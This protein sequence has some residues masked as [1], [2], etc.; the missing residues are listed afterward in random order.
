MGVTQIARRGVSII[1]Q[2]ILEHIHDK[3]T[4]VSVTI[5]IYWPS[6]NW[7]NENRNGDTRKRRE[8]IKRA[9]NKVRHSFKFDE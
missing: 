8:P 6:K 4:S 7:V 1:N 9:E 3:W 5:Y 2:I